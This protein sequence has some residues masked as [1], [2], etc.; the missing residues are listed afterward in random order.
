MYLDTRMLHHNAEVLIWTM[1]LESALN[2]LDSAAT[3]HERI[4][5]LEAVEEARERLES[6]LDGVRAEA[7][8][9]ELPSAAD[10]N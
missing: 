3:R 9:D 7:L 6:L 8:R 1:A 2:R 4:A 5:A 10:V